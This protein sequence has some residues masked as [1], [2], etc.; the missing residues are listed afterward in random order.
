MK[1][2]YFLS[3]SAFLDVTQKL[4]P[5]RGKPEIFTQNKTNT[6]NLPGW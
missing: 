3:T 2:Q 1:Y 4:S 6:T 5:M